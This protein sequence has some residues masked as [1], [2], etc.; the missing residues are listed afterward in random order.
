MHVMMPPMQWPSEHT[1]HAHSADPDWTCTPPSQSAR[2]FHRGVAGYA[3]TDLVELPSI[4]AELGV[5]RV[6]AKFEADRFGLPAF[7]G[8]GASWAIQRALAARQDATADTVIVSATDGNHGRAVA[9]FARLTQH[10]AVIVIPRGVS[11]VAINAIRDE[12]ADVRVIDGDYDAAVQA[13]ASFADEHNGVLVQDTAWVGY[14]EVPGWIVEG[15]ETLFTE[16]DEQLAAAGVT[17]PDLFVVPAGVGSITQAAVAHY[18]ASGRAH[19]TSL[20]NVEPVSAPC[21]LASLASGERV[22]VE[23]SDT[24][25]AGLNC[26]S[27]STLAWPYLMH[28]LDAAVAITDDEDRKAMHDLRALG[29]DAGSCGAACLAG[30]RAALVGDAA[31]REHL[32]IDEA[33]VVVL[34]VTEQRLPGFEA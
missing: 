5:A 6:F 19:R 34:L 23:T 13:A 11:D 9:H 32:R 24:I 12:G 20:L 22:S 25:M 27:V 4:A 3:V 16:I 15:Y 14:E 8:L 2:A 1:W 30:A 33:S 10:P 21:V 26:N 17:A 18:R 29:I 28:G 7:K 31:R